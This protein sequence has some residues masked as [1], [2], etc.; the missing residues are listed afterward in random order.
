MDKT[1]IRLFFQ[2]LKMARQL[3]YFDPTA[4]HH[5]L[6]GMWLAIRENRV[7]LTI[8]DNMRSVWLEQNCQA[9]PFGG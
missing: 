7:D 9:E 5:I 1:S 8:A 6:I 2:L 3:R 4:R